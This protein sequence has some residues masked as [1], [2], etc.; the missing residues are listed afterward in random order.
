MNC[1]PNAFYENE[2]SVKTVL[3]EISI[4]VPHPSKNELENTG[5]ISFVRIQD[6]KYE[7]S[8]FYN[9]QQFRDY[10]AKK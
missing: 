4:F 8:F 3:E 5:V 10:L 2:K 7:P 9:F 1:I 6:N